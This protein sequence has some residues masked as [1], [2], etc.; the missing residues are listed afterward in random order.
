MPYDLN[1]RG[2]MFENELQVIELLARKVPEYG[3]IVEVGSFCGRS[4]TCW[5]L[6]APKTSSIYCY[7][8]FYESLQDDLGE[9]CNTWEI[10]KKNTEKFTNVVPYRGFCPDETKYYD[11]RPIDVFFID[12]VHKNPT[13][14]NII[15]HFLPFVKVGGIIAGHDYSHP[16]DMIFPDVN[17]NVARLEEMYENKAHIDCTL[18]YL[19]KTH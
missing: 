4:T 8:C 2:W 9:Y 7:D 6:S 16:P 3:V 19:T 15:E 1:I 17:E 18:W 14:W 5:A 13:D 10:F 11:S 12:A